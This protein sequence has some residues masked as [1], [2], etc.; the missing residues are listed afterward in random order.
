MEMRISKKAEY[1]LRA[2]V[3]M[4]RGP[5]W[6][7]I[8]EL[9][10]QENIPVKFLEQIM[11]SLKQGG[12][13]TSKRG[14]GGGYSLRMK[15]PEISIGDVVTIIDGPIAPIPCAAVPPVEQCNCPGPVP[16]PVRLTMIEI[17]QDL[18]HSLRR[19][20][21]EDMVRIVPDAEH[22]VFEI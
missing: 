15:P 8:Q 3:A 14:V 6:I 1:A 5:R 7:Q 13:L 9:S 11:L 20:T 17:R 18:D 2:L 4:A 10:R 12:L 16:C 22:L 21:I 19:R